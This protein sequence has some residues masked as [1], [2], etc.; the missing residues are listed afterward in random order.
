MESVEPPPLE[1]PTWT[2][3][4]VLYA[5]WGVLLYHL[6][7]LPWWVASP[8][9]AVLVAWYGNLQHELLHGHPTRS[10]ILNGLFGWMPFGLWMPYHIY[11]ES[12]QEHHKAQILADPV[13]DSE[14]YYFLIKDWQAMNPIFRFVLVVNNTLAGR[15]FV[16]PAIVVGRFLFS[17]VMLILRADFKHLASWTF[18]GILCVFFIYAI[19]HYL[20]ISWWYYVVGIAYPGLSLSLI[21]SFYEHRP[22]DIAEQRTAIV[23]AGPFWS[24][25]FLNNNLHVVHHDHP[26]TAWYLLPGIYREN[27]AE[28]LKKNG[29]FLFD[30]YG[31]IFMQYFIK[32]KDTPIYPQITSSSN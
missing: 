26:A 1:L 30:G 6:S 2:L 8:A 23:E 3:I 32:P 14:S 17:E 9:G 13:T 29:G 5:L 4:L 25:L 12:H 11:I 24:L 31:A 20:E 10:R 28:I 7:I 27:R 18:H 15:M 21:R 19:D 16:G 22:S